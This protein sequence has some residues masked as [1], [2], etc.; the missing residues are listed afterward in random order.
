MKPQLFDEI[1]R[2][3]EKK[4]QLAIQYKVASIAYG[5]FFCLVGVVLTTIEPFK[6]CTTCSIIILNGFLLSLFSTKGSSCNSTLKIVIE[7]FFIYMYAVSIVWI[8][9]MC[10]FIIRSK[11]ELKVSIKNPTTGSNR[12]LSLAMPK[13]SG[14]FKSKFQNLSLLERMKKI[15][16]FQTDNSLNETKRLEPIDEERRVLGSAAD[17]SKFDFTYDYENGKHI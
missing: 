11:R 12:R 14:S 7:S 17:I 13:N 9:L 16:F 3:L 6:T 2:R 4:S 8:I 5:L 1:E 10:F 15:R